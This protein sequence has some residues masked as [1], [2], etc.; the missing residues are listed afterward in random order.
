VQAAVYGIEHSLNEDQLRSAE[1]QH[2][3]M[4]GIRVAARVQAAYMT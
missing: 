1:Q 4:A 3:D 2:I